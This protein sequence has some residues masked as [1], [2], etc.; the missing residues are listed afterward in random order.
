MGLDTLSVSESREIFQAS[1]DTKVKY[2]MYI[3]Q[4]KV[5]RVT[6]YCVMHILTRRDSLAKV[7]VSGIQWKI[8]I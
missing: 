5:Y 2:W 1:A 8:S 6:S 3:N 4:P 7:R